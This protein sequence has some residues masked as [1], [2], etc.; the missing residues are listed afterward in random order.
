MNFLRLNWVNFGLFHTVVWSQG[1]SLKRVLDGLLLCQKSWMSLGLPVTLGDIPRS[2]HPPASESALTS[3]EADFSDSCLCLSVWLHQLPHLLLGLLI[4]QRIWTPS[5]RACLMFGLFVWV[6]GSLWLSEITFCILSCS[7][8]HTHTHTDV[9]SWSFISCHEEQFD[10]V[11]A[12]SVYEVL[13]G[14]KAEENL[15]RLYWWSREREKER[16]RSQH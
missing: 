13:W 3:S 14:I 15:I 2:L 16:K 4:G 6:T 9:Y 11:S 8:T 1:L 12:L 10:S 7:R 5:F